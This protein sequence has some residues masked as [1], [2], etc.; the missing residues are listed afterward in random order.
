L[1]VISPHDSMFSDRRF[2]Q[3]ETH[4]IR[5]SSLYIGTK[6]RER[7]RASEREKE[8]KKIGRRSPFSHFFL[9]TSLSLL[10]LYFSLLDFLCLCDS[11]TLNPTIYSCQFSHQPVCHSVRISTHIQ[12]SKSSTQS[13]YREKMGGVDRLRVRSDFGDI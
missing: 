11:E 9:S 7:E 3:R 13:D 6:M 8:G 12:L 5:V 2:F 4:S 1:A 10:S